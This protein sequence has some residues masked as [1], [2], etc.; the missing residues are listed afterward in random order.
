MLANELTE[1]FES[2]MPKEAFEFGMVNGNL[3][4]EGRVVAPDEPGLGMIV[5][6]RRLPSADFYLYSKLDYSGR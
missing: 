6:W 2:S 5:D 4:H 3:L 1:Y